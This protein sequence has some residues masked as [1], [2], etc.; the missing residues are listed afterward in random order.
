MAGGEKTG[1]RLGLPPPSAAR[2]GENGS[3]TEEWV[4]E[5]VNDSEGLDGS[6]TQE[7]EEEEVEIGAPPSG[8]AKVKIMKEEEFFLK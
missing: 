8:S 5:E 7:Q 4:E 2:P 3:F 1:A 6:E